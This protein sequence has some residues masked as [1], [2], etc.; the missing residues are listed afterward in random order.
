M[1]KPNLHQLPSADLL[2]LAVD[3]LTAFSHRAPALT[4]ESNLYVTVGSLRQLIRALDN[5]LGG[6]STALSRA[7]STGDLVSVDGPFAGDVPAAKQTAQQWLDRASL[8]LSVGPA[9][10]I[11]NAHIALSGLARASEHQLSDDAPCH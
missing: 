2:R 10:S 6:V 9:R 5:A 11:D 3:A 7:E 8:T 4:P 1:E